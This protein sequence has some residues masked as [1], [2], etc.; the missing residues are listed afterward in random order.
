M[1]FLA[2]TH[3]PQS[4][5]QGPPATSAPVPQAQQPSVQNRARRTEVLP[6]PVTQTRPQRNRKKPIR[7]G[8]KS[9]NAPYVK[10]TPIIDDDPNAMDIDKVDEIKP[11]VS[12]AADTMKD[13]M[14]VCSYSRSNWLPYHWYFSSAASIVMMSDLISGDVRQKGAG[15]PCASAWVNMITDAW[16]HGLIQTRAKCVWL[17]RHSYALDA[18]AIKVW[19]WLWVS[20]SHPTWNSR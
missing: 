13:P 14:I 15:T 18:I 8:S 11:V 2:I 16:M 17:R 20:P 6:A 12:E 1:K 3:F 5:T 19:R 10:L 4:I 9:L 7:P